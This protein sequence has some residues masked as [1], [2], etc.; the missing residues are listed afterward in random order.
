VNLN[1]RPTCAAACGLAMVAVTHKQ[2]R[3]F[4]FETSLAEIRLALP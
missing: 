2:F 4:R 1:A 3:D